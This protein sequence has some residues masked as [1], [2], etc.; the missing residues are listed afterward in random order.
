VSSQLII[1]TSQLESSWANSISTPSYNCLFT[2]VDVT[3]FRRND[4]SLAF[5]RAL[6]GQLYLIDFTDNNAKLDTCLIDKTNMG[7]L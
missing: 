1:L 6:D 4:D 2:D 3:V 7:W 5:K